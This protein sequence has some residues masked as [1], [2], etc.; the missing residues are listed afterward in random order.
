MVFFL[1]FPKNLSLKI[2]VFCQ[3]LVI[4]N[5]ETNLDIRFLNHLQFYRSQF[6]MKIWSEIIWLLDS[7][8]RLEYSL[9]FVGD[10]I[11]LLVSKKTAFYLLREGWSSEVLMNYDSFYKIIN[12]LSCFFVE[13]GCNWKLFCSLR[14]R[15]DSYERSLQCRALFNLHGRFESFWRKWHFQHSRQLVL[16]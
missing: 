6:G 15:S 11:N 8:T 3:K 9:T 12:I 13:L 4:L 5:N 2:L 10:L 14:W 16:R 7:K 1:D